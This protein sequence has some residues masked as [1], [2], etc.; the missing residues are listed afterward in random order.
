MQ[1][2]F[3]RVLLLTLAGCST[4]AAADSLPLKPGEY[5]IVTEM[6]IR[7]ATGEPVTETRCI[8]AGQASN[9]EAIFNIRPMAGFCK[10][11]NVA[12]VAGKISYDADCPNTLVKV[13]GTVSADAYSVVRTH[14]PK[15]KG[16]EAASKFQ[17]KRV[18]ACQ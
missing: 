17:G 8:T 12:I 10:L 3:S 13:E 16:V 5:R 9:P 14:K 15:V 4:M 18:G 6:T 1:T 11:G 7:G 2:I